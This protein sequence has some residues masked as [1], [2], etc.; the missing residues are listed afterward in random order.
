MRKIRITF[1]CCCIILVATCL[2]GCT[3]YKQEY[4]RIHVRANSNMACDKEI[5]YLIKAKQVKPPK[6]FGKYGYPETSEKGGPSF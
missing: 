1:I 4:L 2:F 5:K 6:G 3:G